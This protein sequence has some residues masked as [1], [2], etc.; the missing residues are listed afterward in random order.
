MIDRRSS[1]IR[2]L[3]PALH[4]VVFVALFVWAFAIFDAARLRVAFHGD[5]SLKIAT[6][7]YFGYFFLDRDFDH[8]AWQRSHDTLTQPPGF[9]YIVGAGLWLQGHRLEALNQPYNWSDPEGQNRR[10]GRVP[11][12]TVLMDARRVA[13][14]FSAGAVALLYVVGVQL[15]APLAGVAAALLV[16][17]SPYLREHFTRALAESPLV[18]FMLAALALSLWIFRRRPPRFGVTS[19][20]VMGLIL[21]L[22]TMTKLT[23]V[24]SAPA[25]GAACLGAALAARLRGD[26]RGWWRPL[27]WGAAATLLGW[28]LFV[29]LNPFLWP[30]PARRTGD[31]FRYRQFEIDRQMRNHPNVAVRDLGDRVTLILDRALVRRT[32]ASTTLHVPVDVALAAIG[33]GALFLLSWRDWRQRGLIGPAAV[34]IVWLL[35][36]LVGMTWGYGYDQA[37]YIAPIFLLAAL[38]SG[39][40]AEALLRSSI[41]V[42]RLAPE[43]VSR[44][45]RRAPVSEA[46][47][48]HAQTIRAPHPGYHGGRSN[49]WSNR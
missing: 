48:L 31:L 33:L 5:E 37:R 28:A 3:T 45:I 25:L 41:T 7:R 13:V 21:G 16:G 1:I 10:E 12:S 46:T 8:P 9:R 43:A 34:V 26:H 39:V 22:G 42:W 14:L 38:L 17:A 4:G 47:P 35:A 44:Y 11:S 30:A 24:L 36:Y 49:V 20:V 27:T 19:A 15:G 40:G 32:W 18:F 23:A 29:A 6:G 2:R